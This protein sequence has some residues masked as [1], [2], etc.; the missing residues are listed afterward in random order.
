VSMIGAV[1]LLV[2]W[3]R[4]CGGGGGFEVVALVGLD[5]R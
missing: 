5:I 3:D 1:C 2:L 4:G